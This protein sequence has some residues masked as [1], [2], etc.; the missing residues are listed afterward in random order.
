[1][2]RG[3][4]QFLKLW[5]NYAHSGDLIQAEVLELGV[6]RIIFIKLTLKWIF[7]TGCSNIKVKFVFIHLSSMGKKNT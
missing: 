1:M 5:L 4:I 3:F 2:H 6:G 7:K